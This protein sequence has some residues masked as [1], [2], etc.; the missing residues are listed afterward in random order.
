MTSKVAV[1]RM[2][3]NE[4]ESFEQAL[5]LIGGIDELDTSKRSVVV[6]V[7]VFSHRGDNHT[8]VGVV[9]AITNSLINAPRIYLVESDNYQGTGSE[10][11]EI[12]RELFSE[13]VVP[14]NLSSDT[15]TKK[16]SIA[17]REMELSHVLF[18][19]NVFVNTHILRTFRRG[20]VLKNLL[21]CVPDPRKAKFHKNEILCSLL[22][23]IFEAVGGIDLV[24]MDGT[25]LWRGAGDERVR[26]NTLLVSKDAVAVETVGATLAGL[27]PERMSVIQEF[28][29]RGLGEGNIEEIEIVGSSLEDLKGEFRAAVKTLK[30]KWKG[31]PTVWAPAIDKLI[32]EGF[33]GLP[34]KRTRKDVEKALKARGI[35][36][37]GK[38]SVI[39]NTLIRRVRKGTLKGAK[40]PDGWH[41]WTE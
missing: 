31:A 3:G 5:R 20:S 21:G 37:K 28:V 25:Y 19:P 6:K 35:A 15:N 1:V 27:N 10:R 40:S 9:K 26:T 24:V 7:G 34:K 29:K 13:R 41:F 30:K 14:F 8:S 32:Q 12:W 23:D 18:K 33:F 17:G 22:A 36:V 11:L 39:N 16:V 2:Y 4:S 38:G